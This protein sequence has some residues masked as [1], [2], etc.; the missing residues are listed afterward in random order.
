VCCAFVDLRVDNKS[1][2]NFY[3]ISINS[4]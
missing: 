1:I 4:S 2:Y 3:N